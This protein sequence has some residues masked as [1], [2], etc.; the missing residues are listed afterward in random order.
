MKSIFLFL[1]FAVGVFQLFTFVS[2]LFGH[3]LYFIGFKKFGHTQVAIHWPST[4]LIDKCPYSSCQ[5]CKA[6][7][8]PAYDKYHHHWCKCSDCKE[9]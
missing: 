5:D 2:A 7:T 6:W 1:I 9:E 4:W 8:C 3:F